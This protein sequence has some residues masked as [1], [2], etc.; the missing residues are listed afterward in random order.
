MDDRAAL[1]QARSMLMLLL[2]TCIQS[3][4]A[5]GAAADAL[6]T[7]LSEV[8]NAMIE[9]SETELVALNTKI[10]SLSA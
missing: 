5:L 3:Q 4:T 6:D 1:I 7:D 9:R 8:L 10:D 2:A